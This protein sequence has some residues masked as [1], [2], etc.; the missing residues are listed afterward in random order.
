MTNI[1]ADDL[2]RREVHYRVSSLVSKLAQGYGACVPGEPGDLADMIEQA[3]DLAS[4]VDDWEEAALQAGWSMRE[5]GVLVHPDGC[6]GTTW[7]SVCDH[8]GIDPYQREV[9]EHWIVSDWLADK[10]AEKGEKVDKD[11]AGMTVWAR[12]TTGQGIASDSVIEA[13]VDDLN[14][15]A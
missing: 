2:A 14:K 13:I 6:E 4:P 10:L 3:F 15:G 9:F 1:T 5:D 7:E 11:F 8:Y 12:T